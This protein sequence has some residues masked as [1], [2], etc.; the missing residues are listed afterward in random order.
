[1]IKNIKISQISVTGIGF[2]TSMIHDMPIIN[3][4]IPITIFKFF[5]VFF[6]QYPV[7][8]FIYFTP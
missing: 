8:H 5:S 7:Q 4:T 2:K 3:P 1:M 6:T